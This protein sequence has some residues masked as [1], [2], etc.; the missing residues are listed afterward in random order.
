MTDSQYSTCI[1]ILYVG[2]I[3]AQIPSNFLLN[4]CGRPSLYLPLWMAA[5]GVRVPASTACLLTRGC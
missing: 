5:W 1:S 3:F 4:W 2:Y